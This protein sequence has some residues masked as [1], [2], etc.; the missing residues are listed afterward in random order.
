[1]TQQPN[2]ERILLLGMISTP[3]ARSFNLSEVC[4]RI[5]G[6]MCGY[7]VHQGQEIVIRQ[8]GPSIVVAVRD[9]VQSLFCAAD[10]G[11]TG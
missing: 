9:K 8:E 7:S 10:F 6:A 3:D 2:M 5:V 11:K 4:R 1:M